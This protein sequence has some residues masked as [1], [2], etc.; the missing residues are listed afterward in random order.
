MSQ[1]V[2]AQWLAWQL[3]T[4][5]KLAIYTEWFTDSYL[6]PSLFLISLSPYKSVPGRWCRGRHPTLTR[7]ECV[8]SAKSIQNSQNAYQWAIFLAYLF[9][10]LSIVVRYRYRYRIGTEKCYI[11]GTKQEKSWL[12]LFIEVFREKSRNSVL[13]GNFPNGIE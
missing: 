7:S 3:A 1:V 9:F 4:S 10:Y 8:R 5:F 12:V 2:I 11:N 6:T 13:F